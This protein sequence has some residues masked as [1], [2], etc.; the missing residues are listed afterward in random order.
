MT[1]EAPRARHVEGTKRGGCC[2][3]VPAL[4]HSRARARLGAQ[5]DGDDLPIASYSEVPEQVPFRV[6]NASDGKLLLAATKE[7]G[8]RARK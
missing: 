6:K 8:K 1:A 7:K 2:V 5:G 4:K 3:V